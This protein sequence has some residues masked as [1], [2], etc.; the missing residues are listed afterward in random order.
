MNSYSWVQP[1]SSSSLTLQREG[2]PVLQITKDGGLVSSFTMIPS[3]P[4]D[5]TFDNPILVIDSSGLVK[6]STIS[7]A[8]IS[9]EINQYF[10]SNHEEMEK[11]L[12]S[13]Q[14]EDE[15]AINKVVSHVNTSLSTIQNNAK[16]EIS[17][18]LKTTES[19]SKI[20]SL[21]RMVWIMFF[22]NLL[23]VLA[24]VRLFFKK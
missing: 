10:K 14:K 6:R 19:T 12:A 13:I 8:K 22:L 1:T 17:Q 2:K 15:K 23:L 5:P 21:E 11:V 20:T 3:I 24:V 16:H 9:E 7:L 4:E 18:A